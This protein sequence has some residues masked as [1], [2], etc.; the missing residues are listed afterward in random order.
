[1]TGTSVEVQWLRLCTS[2]AVSTGTKILHRPP[3]CKKKPIKNCFLNFIFRFFI[4]N[5]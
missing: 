5:V 3:P 1:M 2:T 4:A